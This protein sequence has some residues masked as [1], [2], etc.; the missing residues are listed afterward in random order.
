[1]IKSKDKSFLFMNAWTFSLDNA[2]SADISQNSVYSKTLTKGDFAADLIT[3][4]CDPA[5][6]LHM[7]V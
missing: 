2:K 7:L 6:N 5:I 1:M 4:S 3:S